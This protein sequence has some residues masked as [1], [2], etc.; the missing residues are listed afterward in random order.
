MWEVLFRFK[1]RRPFFF[2]GLWSEDS[3][4]KTRGFALVTGKP[5]ELVEALPH[6]RMPVLLDEAG[7]SAW[8]GS[9]PLPDGELLGLCAP[10]PA[11]DMERFDLPK[12]KVQMT[13]ELQFE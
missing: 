11:T 5:N 10:Y 9:A 4:D 6:N 7:A 13:D 1:D 8:L 2:A 12:R 3:V